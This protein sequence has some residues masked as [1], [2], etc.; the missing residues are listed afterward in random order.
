M[1]VINPTNNDI[2]VKIYG[3]TYTVKA[4][5][6]LNN[7]PKEVATKWVEEMHSFLEIKEEGEKTIASET[8]KENIAKD[9]TKKDFNEEEREPS[10][11]N[12]NSEDEDEEEEENETEEEEVV[13]DN[14]IV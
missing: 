14:N 13:V 6:E 10:E 12:K 5:S 3:T 9:E 7:V 8:P 11:D 1:K 4:N 2:A